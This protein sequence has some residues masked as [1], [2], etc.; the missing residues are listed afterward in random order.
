MNY[1]LFRN[2]V[3]FIPVRWKCRMEASWE[4]ISWGPHARLERERKICRRLFTSSMKRKIRHFHVEVVRWRQRNVQKKAWC[5]CKIVVLVNKPI[6]FLSFSSP[7]PSQ[8]SALQSSKKQSFLAKV[9]LEKVPTT[10][11]R[12]VC[13]AP[14]WEG[15]ANRQL[16]LIHAVEL[17]VSANQPSYED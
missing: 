8:S 9:K 10:S 1:H 13:R 17:P 4:V 15:Q 12:F 11:L 2:L 5:T 3:A 14:K 6:A 7:S 16:R